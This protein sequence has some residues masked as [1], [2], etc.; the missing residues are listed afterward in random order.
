MR[1]LFYFK[2]GTHL[3]DDEKQTIDCPYCVCGEVSLKRHSHNRWSY[4]CNLCIQGGAHL[5]KTFAFP[6][7]ARLQFRKH[8][9]QWGIGTVELKQNKDK[10][11]KTWIKN[12]I[13]W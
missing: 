2:K 10:R 3:Q 6:Y 4:R 11:L 7:Q 12:I 1:S 5:T 13:Q 9:E 8:A